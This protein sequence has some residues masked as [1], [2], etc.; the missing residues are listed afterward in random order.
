MADFGDDIGPPADAGTNREPKV[1]ATNGESHHGE[2]T[3]AATG[4]T[5]LAA[6]TG[7]ASPAP[8]MAFI[9]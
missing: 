3:T 2:T 1:A 7:D 8:V 4:E 5:K 9:C 6:I